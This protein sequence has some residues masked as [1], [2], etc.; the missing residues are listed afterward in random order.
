[1]IWGRMQLSITDGVTERLFALSG[2]A[3]QTLVGQQTKASF[4]MYVLGL[5]SSLPNKSVEPVQL[6]SLDPTDGRRG[7]PAYTSTFGVA[8][9]RYRRSS[10]SDFLCARRASASQ[11]GSNACHRRYIVSQKGSASV[12]VKQQYC[13][14]LGKKWPM[15]GHR[16]AHRSDGFAHLLS[17]WNHYAKGMD[18]LPS[19]A[20]KRAYSAG[21]DVSRP[22]QTLRFR[23][24]N[25]HL[26]R[27]SQAVVLADGLMVPTEKF[28]DG[29]RK[30]GLHYA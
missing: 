19:S 30:L 28:R 29:V 2:T 14:A 13:G 21:G 18:G 9:A 3:R 15:S 25:V 4:A 16:F 20:G 5:L 24:S 27:N 6:C 22:N 12:G 23:S 7:V 10:R 1:M 26:K 8:P 11:P 17:I